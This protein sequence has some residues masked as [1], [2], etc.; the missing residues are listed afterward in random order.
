MYQRNAGCSAQDLKCKLSSADYV[1]SSPIARNCGVQRT[2]GVDQ[3]AKWQKLGELLSER[4]GHPA[5]DEANEQQRCHNP[6]PLS[7]TASRPWPHERCSEGC[8]ALYK[9]FGSSDEQQGDCA[10]LL[11]QGTCVPV[12]SANISV[13]VTSTPRAS[14][15]SPRHPPVCWDE[16][17]T[18]VWQNHHL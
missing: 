14:E 12:L 3:T 7:S 8:V 6:L 17:P 11:M 5:G 18:G 9:N 1:Y 10:A 2:D 16:R 13:A 15:V 4:L